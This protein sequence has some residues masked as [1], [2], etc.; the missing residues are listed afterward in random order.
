MMM[1]AVT[2]T[3]PAVCRLDLT[4]ASFLSVF[5]ACEIRILKTRYLLRARLR[6]QSNLFIVDA[7]N[8][9]GNLG[10]RSFCTFSQRHG[11]T[12][13]QILED[14]HEEQ[15]LMSLVGTKAAPRNQSSGIGSLV[16]NMNEPLE[17]HA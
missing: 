9:K 1:V 4:V 5:K 7:R 11:P 13:Q 15:G 17:L 14:D 6:V 10:P 12:Y 3:F 2:S 8:C 16:I